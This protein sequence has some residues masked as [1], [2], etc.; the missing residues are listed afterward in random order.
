M[1]ME[2]LGSVSKIQTKL[3][4]V[5]FKD[6]CNTISFEALGVP[7]ISKAF[8][9][10]ACND[11]HFPEDFAENE[12]VLGKLQLLFGLIIAQYHPVPG[13]SQGSLVLFENVFR[14]CAGGTL[15]DGHCD[16]FPNV[17]QSLTKVN[18]SDIGTKNMEV[19]STP[20]CGNCKCVICPLGAA[21]LSIKEQK[22]MY[23]MDSNVSFGKRS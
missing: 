5:H 15:S 4:Q 2:T 19:S 23:M 8:Y 7:E 11:I 6:K 20:K 22:E 14:L 10:L 18:V 21:V 13:K 1:V 12:E 3:Y 17:S 9:S 16:R